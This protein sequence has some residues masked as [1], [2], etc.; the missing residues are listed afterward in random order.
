MLKIAIWMM[1]MWCWWEFSCL[2]RLFDPYQLHLHS[3]LNTWLQWIGQIQLTAR[4]DDKHL[5]FRIWC[6]I[7]YSFNS[8]IS[9]V[10]QANAGGTLYIDGLVQDC[11]ISSMLAMEI[12]M[13]GTKPSICTSSKSCWSI[14]HTLIKHQ[15]TN[16][17]HISTLLMNHL[18]PVFGKR[19]FGSRKYSTV[20][21]VVYVDPRQT[22]SV[23]LSIFWCIISQAIPKFWKYFFNI[24]GNRFLNGRWCVSVDMWNADYI[25]IFLTCVYLDCNLKH[26]LEDSIDNKSALV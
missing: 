26:I 11:S 10:K 21:N 18:Y 25:Y 9:C 15:E 23:F 6:N 1:V 22:H 8:V 13:S 7:Y 24:F 4:L 5:I 12:L 17:H 3:Q 14:Y 19:K 20:V 16:F 2:D